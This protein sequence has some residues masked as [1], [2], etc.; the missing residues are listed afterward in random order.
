MDFVTRPILMP[1]SA[2][3]NLLTIDDLRVSFFLDEGTVN[4]VS[5][6]RLS[7]PRG[8][9][10]ALVGE[11]GCGKSVTS[12][13]VLRLLPKVGRITG[14]RIVLHRDE[15]VDL[16]RLKPDGR[17]IRQIRGNQVAMIFQE[18]MSSL[19]PVHMVGSQ[20]AEAVLL[21]SDCRRA[22]ARQRAIEMM[23]KVGIPDS[24]RR[25]G[26][27]PHEMSGGLRQRAVIAMALA[28]RPALLIADEPTT[29]LDVTIQAQILDLMRGLQQEMGMSLLLITHDLG[30]V[31]QMADEVAVMYMGRVVEQAAT[32]ELYADP[33]HPYTREL[34]RSIPSLRGPRRA[35]LEAIAGSVPDPFAKLAGCPF[36]PRCPEFEPG[37]CNIGQPPELVQLTQGHSA[38]C[39]L[40]QRGASTARVVV[41]AD[42][43]A[44]AVASGGQ[45]LL[46]VR[47]L[48]KH[49]PI[50]GG[51]FKRQIGAVRA[52]DGVSFDLLDGE[53]L[54][55]VGESGSGKTT[56]GRCILR[57]HDPT[58]GQIF[59]RDGDRVIDV[60]GASAAE[61]RA[62]RRHMQM[63]F[64]DPYSSLN[65]RMTVLDIIGEPLLVNG[66]RS[67]RDRE[68]RVRE[69]LAAVGLNPQHLRRYPHAFSG[70]QR[71]RIGLARALALNPRLIVADEP[72]S[73]LDVS[74]QAQVLNLLAELQ[75][76]YHLTYLFVAHDLSV[77]RHISQR[78]AVMYVGKIVELAPVERLFERPMHP[79]TA[80]LLASVPE[81]DPSVRSGRL[82]LAG[83]TADPSKPP[84]G[85]AFHSRCAFAQERCRTEVPG[86]RELA[87]GHQVRCHLAEQLDLT[88]PV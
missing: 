47:D 9:T 25:F 84:S 5:G 49:F 69:L 31:A 78:V 58:A 71:Q 11:S 56:V 30:V 20:I 2:S 52:V 70:G 21:H 68:D 64:Q 24:P 42:T 60:A 87:G 51:F 12:F 85:C 13:A 39:F 37:L 28:C 63:I 80:A 62:I 73:A 75:Q 38:A 67:R 8:K 32:R 23:Q 3:S 55:L 77:V 40:R 15:D 22:Q 81:P 1:D 57:A 33:Q 6:V 88:Q 27:Y 4:A 76:K 65:P 79:Y 54:G 29:A 41:T 17:E 72:V 50:Y 26:Q 44:P 7:I 45:V 59:F 16:T 61:M 74:V 10:L 35:R 36:H 19:S 14:G 48:R 43:E 83:E 66:M 53:C 82:A 18:P 86:L 46:S 34:M